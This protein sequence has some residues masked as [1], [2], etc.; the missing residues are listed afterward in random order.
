MLL[1]F[2]DS[3]EIWFFLERGCK[4]SGHVAGHI[5]N[6]YNT[7]FWMLVNKKGKSKS[8][9]QDY[10]KVL[11]YLFLYCSFASIRFTTFVSVLYCNPMSACL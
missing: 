3:A 11:R 9:A 5:N 6:Q 4:Y 8:E 2:V 10:L 7:C 1:T